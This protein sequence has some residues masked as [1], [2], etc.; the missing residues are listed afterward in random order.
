MSTE[1]WLFLFAALGGLGGLAAVGSFLVDMLPTTKTGKAVTVTKRRFVF[2]LSLLCVSLTLSTV[3]FAVSYQRI[4]IPEWSPEDQVYRQYGQNP[5]PNNC[6]VTANGTRFWKYH[7]HYKLVAGCFVSDALT[8]MLDAVQLQLTNSYD[9][10]QGDID[11][12]LVWGPGFKEHIEKTHAPGL[13]YVL[14]MVPIG[15]ESGQVSTLRQAKSLGA[16]IV[17]EGA[18]GFTRLFNAQPLSQ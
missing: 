1:S 12:R 6:T 7:E 4:D 18:T 5:E 2:I 17:M 3:G 14:M 9:I 8:D 10:R 15:F 11:M 16:R 13:N